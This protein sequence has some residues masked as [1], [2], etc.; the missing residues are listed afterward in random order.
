MRA[1]TRRRLLVS[2]STVLAAPLIA[3]VAQAA[4]KP[5]RIG[6]LGDMTGPYSV[7]S[8]INT[9]AATKLAIADFNQ[10]HPEIQV[11][12]VSADFQL[13]PDIGIS[14]TRQW[15]EEGG[16]DCI[17]DVPMSALA[18]GLVNLCTQK[19]KVA[20]F[21]GTATEDLTGK[22]C[23]PNHVHWTYDSYS[24][25]TTVARALLAKKLDRWFFIAADYAMGASV[26]RDASAAI[27]EAGGSVLG[28]VRHPFPGTGDFSSYLLQAQASGANVICFA[29][30][31]E[32]LENSV[33]Q[34]KEFNIES[35]GAVLTAMLMDV[36]TV[37][38]IGLTQAQGLYYSNA[39]YWDMN[40]NTRA[41]TRRLVAVN[42]GTYPAQ[43]VAGAYS[44][45]LH[46]LKAVAALGVGAAQSSGRAVVA[47]MKA[48]PF[49]D[50]VFGR[51]TVRAD[52]RMMNNTY[53][54]QVKAPGESTSDWDCSKL[55]G[56]VSPQDGIRSIASGSCTM[57]KG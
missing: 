5:I 48:E 40:D 37:R 35:K 1:L 7:F 8:G 3:R 36:P 34:A 4:A 31:G 25:A 47:Q 21:T 30:A 19:D 29:N 42:N 46:Y 50:P 16:V 41:F 55:A 28:T 39:F 20:L 57:A 13:K 2:A 49:D 44:A 56:T 22:A 15:F 51:G 43:N 53:L 23:S 52:G 9:I 26:V 45:T 14:I 12:V 10:L 18:L 17:I 32:D 24:L 11:D 54:F 38:A 27:T 6:V 33:K